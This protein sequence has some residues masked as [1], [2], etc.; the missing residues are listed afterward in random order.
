[1]DLL[2]V[3]E[4]TGGAERLNYVG[5]NRVARECGAWI[6]L[7]DPCEDTSG[8]VVGDE[9]S[10]AS[11]Y[12]TKPFF[13]EALLQR[14][15]T[16]EQPDDTEWTIKALQ[17]H[18]EIVIGRALVV[19]AITGTDSYTG[20]AD[21]RSVTWTTTS[22]ATKGDSVAA[23]RKLW[24]DTV[25]GAG[26]HPIMHVPPSIAPALGRAGILLAGQDKNLWGDKVVINGGY[27]SANPRVFW[28]GPIKVSLSS[29][30]DPGLFRV[31]R[32]NDS[33]V[34]V[35]QMALVDVAPCSIIRIGTYS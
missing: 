9:D 12:V 34:S 17:E 16:C 10:R 3:A 32:T 21:V 28:T 15:V 2:D 26:V 4:V 20:H 8:D 27:D 6:R 13:Y 33:T 24:V 11:T 19:Q 22:D 18:N 5:E 23:G 25:V 31:P 29:V 14:S 35:N 7:T 1:M 30:D